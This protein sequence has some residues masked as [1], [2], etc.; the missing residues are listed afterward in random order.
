MG[1]DDASA[2]RGRYDEIAQGVDTILLGAK[3]V[4]T[5]A[6]VASFNLKGQMQEKKVRIRTLPRAIRYPP[7]PRAAACVA[8]H[9]SAVF[10]CVSTSPNVAS[11]HG[12][13]WAASRA[14]SAAACTWPRRSAKGAQFCSRPRNTHAPT[15]R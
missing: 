3:E 9:P 11:A 1:S 2:R 10:A 4:N 7:T 8:T 5:R 13:R 15:P 14:V 6:Y 12:G